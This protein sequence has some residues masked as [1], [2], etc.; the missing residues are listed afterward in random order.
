VDVITIPGHDS[1]LPTPID[2][3]F[4]T[5]ATRTTNEV[6]NGLCFEKDSL[7]ASCKTQVEQYLIPYGESF[8]ERFAIVPI[9]LTRLLAMNEIE[10]PATVVPI[11]P[12]RI[13]LIWRILR[14]PLTRFLLGTIVLILIPWLPVIVLAAGWLFFTRD[15]KQL[16]GPTFMAASEC[17]AAVIALPVYV[18]FVRL[19]EWRRLTELSPRRAVREFV[20]GAVTGFGLIS[21]IMGVLCAFGAFQ[22][23][24]TAT[25]PA[26]LLIPLV[27][28]IGSGIYEEIL[29]RGLWFRV[30]EEWLG[31]AVGLVVSALIFGLLHM[32]NP[33]ATLASC[34]AISFEAGLLLAAAFMLTRRLWMSIGLHAAWNFTLGGVYGAGVSGENMSGLLQLKRTGPDWL[35]G[36]DFG[37]EGSVVTLVVCTA[38]GVTLLVLA[39]RRGSRVPMFGRRVA[40]VPAVTTAASNASGAVSEFFAFADDASHPAPAEDQPER[41]TNGAAENRPD[42]VDET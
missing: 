33:G 28:G 32:F 36:G 1:P 26:V 9:L 35:T 7:V 14:Y 31:S 42:I 12:I 16:E 23:E 2:V 13:A 15:P 21:V 40:S 4:D 37:P 5:G 18:A 20:V 24:G 8:C 11:P 25:T 17:I 29:A 3:C 6:L 27:I 10:L 39:V 41:R 30:T 22:F 34:L 38:A 19:I